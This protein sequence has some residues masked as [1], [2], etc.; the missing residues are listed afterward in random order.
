MASMTRGATSGVWPDRAIHPGTYLREEIETRG[1]T[2]TELAGRMERPVQVINEVIRGRKAI[3]EETALG[4]ERVLGTPARTWLNLQSMYGLVRAR[5]Q[6]EGELEKQA[7][8]LD[9]FPV[10]EMVQRNWIAPSDSAAD[11]VRAL[12][13]FFGLQSFSAWDERQAA[14]G[15]RLSPRAQ[16]DRFALHTWVRQGEIEGL[17]LPTAPYDAARFRDVLS[18]IRGLTTSRDFWTPMRELCASAGI[19]LVAV[20]EFPKTGAQGVARWLTSGKALIQINLRYR[21]ADIFWFTFFHEAFHVLRHPHR[22]IF[23]DVN[24]GM[25]RDERETEADQLAAD[26]L[27]P[28]QEWT[29]FVAANAPNRADVMRFATRVGIAPGIVV[30]RLQHEKL[31]PHNQLND[32]RVRLEYADSD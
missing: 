23:V 18:E 16:T 32:L 13:Q 7:D 5:L 6:E 4:L 11:Q 24:S 3:S 15:F 21:W 9:H 30:G 29:G 12:L 31:V 19:A 2:Q 28:R 8:W 17:S 20:R 1:M 26:F 22:E 14:L 27:I 10:N 25:V